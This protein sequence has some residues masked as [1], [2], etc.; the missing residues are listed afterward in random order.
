MHGRTDVLLV[1]C[2]VTRFKASFLDLEPLGIGWVV[3]V[4]CGVDARRHV[5]HERPHVMRP[6]NAT[7]RFSSKK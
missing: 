1:P 2:D 5:G 4:A 7:F 3:L 6:L